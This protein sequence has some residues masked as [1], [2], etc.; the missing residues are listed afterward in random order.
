MVQIN[1]N[2][3][4]IKQAAYARKIWNADGID[5]QHIALEV[6][7]SKAVARSP[8]QKIENSKGYHNEVLRLAKDSNNLALSAM[9]EFKKRGFK[10]FKNKELIAALSAIASAWSRFNKEPQGEKKP[11]KSNRL[12]TVILEQVENQIVETPKI[13]KEIKKYRPSI[14]YYD[15]VQEGE[16]QTIPGVDI[17][18]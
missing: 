3:S 13:P 16:E 15:E 7:Y 4:T 17:D 18:F 1:K 11:K 14:G 5:R 6:G 9:E 12:R 8:R 2:G 10:E